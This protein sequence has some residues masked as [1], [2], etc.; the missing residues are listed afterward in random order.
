MREYAPQLECYKYDEYVPKIQIILDYSNNQLRIRDNGIGMS[1]EVLKN[2][3]LTLGNRT[4]NLT[5]ICIREINI[6]QLE[7]SE[8]V[9]GV[10]YAIK[11][12][13]R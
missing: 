11:R 8:L 6:I 7:I 1:E 4:I 3:F 9:F 5:T 13:Y 12:S 10:F 2:I